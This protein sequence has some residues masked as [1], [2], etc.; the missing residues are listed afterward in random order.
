M[1][2]VKMAKRSSLWEGRKGKSCHCLDMAGILKVN[3]K[4]FIG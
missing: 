1:F 4:Q 2:M 3:L